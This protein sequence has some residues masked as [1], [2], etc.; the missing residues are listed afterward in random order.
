M[1]RSQV[2]RPSELL[3][4]ASN[5]LRT[6][7]KRSILALLGIA[8]GSA[9]VIALINIGNNAATQAQA[10]F[11]GMGVDTLVMRFAEP[12]LTL[13]TAQLYTRVPQLLSI[14]P[15]AQSNA[16]VVFRGNS[17]HAA[18]IGTH[19]SLE[20]AMRL[21]LQDGRFLSDFDQHAT[22]AVVGH[23]LAQALAAGG[24]PLQVGDQVRINA[25]LYQVLGIL[26]D[27]P[28]NLL[29]SIRTGDSLFVPLQGL[30]RIDGRLRLGEVVMRAAPDADMASLVLTVRELIERTY[31]KQ[32]LDILIAQQM[33][34]GMSHQ[35]RTFSYLLMALA[36]V[37]LL[38][39]GVGVMNVM[40][41]NIAQRKREIGVRMALGARRRDIRY[42]FLLEALAL[43]AIGAVLGAIA[44]LAFAWAYSLLSG[45]HFSFA[46]S[47][48]VLG[49][50]STLLVGLFFGLYPA[51]AAS[52][53]Q[54]LEA[55]REE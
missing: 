43:T 26:Q 3:R 41:M 20:H 34:E 12:P 31:G 54:P 19:P 38:A 25:Y 40:V 10:L 48:L 47:S 18:I 52:N 53:L 24:K 37:S 49:I 6:L 23:R 32:E 15:T 21:P 28:D 11:K 51:M 13:D 7:G 22:F 50:G 35:S 33:I 14:A 27:Q 36:S 30:P 16:S 45:W 44:G 2:Q 17:V 29:V 42:L 46:L 8:M 9:L 5:S 4:E 55:L 39:G 1:I